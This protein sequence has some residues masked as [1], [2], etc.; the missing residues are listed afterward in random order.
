[1]IPSKSD[2]DVSDADLKNHHLLLIGRP[3]TNAVTAKLAAALPV[4]FGAGSFELRDETY[5][6]ERSAVIAAGTNPHNPRYSVV[7]YAGLSGDA[8]SRAI[9]A[10]PD[11]DSYTAQVM[12][13]PAHK[14]SR[15]FC[16]TPMTPGITTTPA[17]SEK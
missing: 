11:E 4:K 3:A 6:S 16:V 13:F 9:S 5:A 7:A 17:A 8:T 15:R 2:Q 12:V 14:K 1:M 10:L